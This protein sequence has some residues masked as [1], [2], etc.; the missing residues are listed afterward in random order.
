MEAGEERSTKKKKNALAYNGA[1]SGGKNEKKLGGASLW[2]RFGRPREEG[3]HP[4]VK[5]PGDCRR[6]PKR[7]RTANTEG[8]GP[9]GSC[10]DNKN[11]V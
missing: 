4:W 9:G 1:P 11:T 3:S 5:G 10:F 6:V 8:T 7:A 2:G